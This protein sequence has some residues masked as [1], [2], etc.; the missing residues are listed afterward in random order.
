MHAVGVSSSSTLPTR[1][2]PGAALLCLASFLLVTGPL[3]CSG[4]DAGGEAQG[5]AAPKPPVALGERS[6]GEGTYY[7]ANGSGAC[8]FDTVSGPL[9]VAALNAPDWAG[10]ALC[11][12]CAQVEGPNGSVTVRI[13]D[14]CPECRSGD[15]DLS[16]QAFAELAP[17]EQGRIPIEWTLASCEVTGPLRYLY[18]DGSNPWW[19]AVQVR[20]HRLPI[21][22]FE[23]APAGGAFQE[24]ARTDYNYF[25]TESGFGEGAVR[26]RVTAVDGQVLEDDLPPVQE[27]LETPGAAQ[28]E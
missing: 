8:S 3:A 2:P 1:Q 21:A 19:T 5:G 17:L 7:D 23:W 28:F 13:V 24:L 16:P 12:A 4:E 20:N 10:S 15:L 11:G 26:V 18:K 9:F 25:L 27:G 6:E 22:K 14:Q